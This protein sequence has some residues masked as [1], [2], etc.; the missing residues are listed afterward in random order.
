MNALTKISV[1]GLTAAS[2][3]LTAGVAMAAKVK[4]P[5]EKCFGIT[6]AGENDCGNLSGTH[7]CQGQSTVDYA[8]DEWQFVP[9]GTCTTTVVTDAEGHA[10]KG[11]TKAEAKAML[12][13]K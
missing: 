9:K 7:S 13:K 5:K 4:G 1:T 6:K 11:L 8:I 12:A 3:A 2:F 10:H